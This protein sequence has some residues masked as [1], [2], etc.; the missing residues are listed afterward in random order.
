L[1]KV[2]AELKE[3]GLLSSLGKRFGQRGS[4]GARSIKEQIKS[5][6]DELDRDFGD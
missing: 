2:V 6:Y 1:A 4:G 3:K 5:F